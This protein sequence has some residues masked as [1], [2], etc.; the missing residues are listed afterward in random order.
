MRLLLNSAV[1]RLLLALAVV[2]SLCGMGA[3]AASAAVGAPPAPFLESVSPEGLGGLVSW[4]PEATTVGV[5]TYSVKAVPAPGVKLPAGCSAPPV[6]T[7]SASNSAAVVKG[8]CVGVAYVAQVQATNATGTSAWG[9][10]SNPFAALPAQAPD[11]ALITRVVGRDGSLVVTWSAPQLDGGDPI[12]GYTIVASANGATVS[13]TAGST[14]TAAVV[15]GLTNGTSYAVSVV[16]QSDAGSSAPAGSIGTPSAARAPTAPNDLQAVPAGNGSGEVDLSWAPPTDDGGAAISSYVV[17]YEQMTTDSSGNWQPA[18]GASPTTVTVGGNTTSDAI[19]GLTPTTGFWSFSVA[20]VNSVGTGLAVS[21]IDPVSPDAESTAATVVLTPATM[22][23]LASDQNGVLTWPAPAPAQLTSLKKGQVMVAAPASSAPAGLLDTVKSVKPT[24]GGG[25]SVT[26]TPAALT[27]AFSNLSLSSSSDPVGTGTGSAGTGAAFFRPAAA[28]V[29]VLAY[30]RP[31]ALAGVTLS[32]D[33]TLGIDFGSG[34]AKVSGELEL[35]PSVALDVALTHALG[36]PDGAKMTAS[37]T[38]TAKASVA[39]TLHGSQTKKIG[40][41]DGSPETLAIGPIPV[42]VVPKIPV[43]LTVSGQVGTSATASITVGG[44]VSWSSRSP[45]TL[46]VKNL[47]TPPQISGNPL[48][49]ISATAA[50]GLKEQ[51][52]LALYDTAGPNIEADE[53]LV[54]TVNPTP[55]SGQNY[56]SLTPSILLKAGWD[57]DLLHV[58]ASLEATIAKLSFTPFTIARAPAAFLTLAPHDG[59]VAAGGTL[60][61]SATRSDGQTQPITWRVLGGA[62]DSIGADGVLHAVSPTGRTFAVTARDATGATGLSYVTVG[63]PFDPPAGLRVAGSSDGKTATVSWQPPSRTGG[64]PIS[65]YTVTSDPVSQQHTLT[66]TTRITSI[67]TDPTASYVISAYATNSHGLRSPPATLSYTP[68]AGAKAVSA[69]GSDACALLLSNTISCWGNNVYGQLGNGGTTSL[70]TPTPVAGITNATAVAA[71]GEHTCAI[72]SGG[73][74]CWGNNNDGQLG[75]GSTTDSST[76]VPVTGIGNATAIATSEYNSCAVLADGTVSCWGLDRYHQLGDGGTGGSQGC[77]DG[78]CSSIPL[79][80]PGIT[81]ATQVAIGG[82]LNDS[83]ACALLTTGKIT[84]WG[85]ND[86]GQLGDG[87]TGDPSPPV[88]V[89]GISDAVQLTGSYYTMCAVLSSGS[90]DCWGFGNNGELGRGTDT[91]SPL[92]APVT[93][94]T[95]AVAAGGGDPMCALLADGSVD[96]WGESANGGLGNG[97]D[98]GPDTCGQY[99]FP[100]ARTPVSVSGPLDAASV[101]TGNTGACVVL[102]N[103]SVDCWGWNAYGQLGDGTSGSDSVVPGPVLGIG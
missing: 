9:V 24:S 103:A 80:V 12:L 39:A 70:S 20:A 93:G 73:V 50:I 51:P 13:V 91:S 92:P 41:I 66:S 84:C 47:S 16:A 96:C 88:T 72:A 67:K 36:V 38:M 33:V 89:S 101:S 23:G 71:A 30:R 15:S 75:N 53:N 83:S 44:E 77:T 26:V 48:E 43:Y 5:V 86:Y 45:G 7:V 56:F 58:H 42:V 87:T 4:A 11:P 68:G 82:T 94:V 46:A 6:V 54:A 60:A 32:R 65:S 2:V 14:A 97:S 28:G 90:V 27:D 98:V 81:N 34:S 78:S 69:S 8:L 59:S 74:D 31:T 85:S 19:T 61:F 29:R 64:Y 99:A 76:P 95:N 49:N 21:A 55:Q 18:A 52:Q 62:G 22:A 102:A 3:H 79:S 1:R 63:Q 35:N 37:A 57:V 25:Y 10:K 17:T 100:C 40:E